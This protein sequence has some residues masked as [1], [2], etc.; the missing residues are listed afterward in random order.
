MNINILAIVQYTKVLH[1]LHNDYP[2]APDK[3]EIKREVLSESQ[4]KT[5]DLCNIPIGIV[6]KLE[7]RKVRK[8]FDSL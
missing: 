6:K 2:L 1:K 4:L 7:L 3:I 5:A 8:V